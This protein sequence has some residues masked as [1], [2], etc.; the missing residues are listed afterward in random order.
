MIEFQKKI[1]IPV[2]W[3]FF[4][5]YHGYNPCDLAAAHLNAA[6]KRA[7]DN[8]KKELT[9][10]K[11]INV[12][13]SITCHRSSELVQCDA[14]PKVATMKNISLYHHFQY[15]DGSVVGKLLFPDDQQGNVYYTR[16]QN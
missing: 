8:E 1:Q 13:N 7:K 14:N 16:S 5:S 6:T 15:T 3:N 4:V 9:L 10:Q 12:C 11:V 2:E